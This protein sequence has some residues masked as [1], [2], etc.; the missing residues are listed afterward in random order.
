MDT[1]FDTWGKL[2]K[3]LEIRKFEAGPSTIFTITPDFDTIQYVEASTGIDKPDEDEAVVSEEYHLEGVD[4]QTKQIYDRIK[5]ISLEKDGSLIFNIR[6]HYISIKAD[7]NIAF[8]LIRKKKIRFIAMMPELQIRDI[9]NYYSVT[10]LSRGVQDFYNGPCATI[11]IVDLS[12]DD[13]L[14]A[15]IGGLIDHYLTPNY[16]Q[17]RAGDSAA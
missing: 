17:E 14:R 5:A 8:L 3:F 2:V 16:T 7:K 9:A 15:L 6:K 11:D 1:Y 10:S 13:E 4:E 12:H